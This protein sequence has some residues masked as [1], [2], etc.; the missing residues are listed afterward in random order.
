MLALTPQCKIFLAIEP[1]DFRKGI[2]ALAAVCRQKLKEEPFSGTLFV[3]SNRSRT[4]I[5]ILTYDG[6]GFWLLMQRLSRGKF[7]WW[8]KADG[9][10]HPL[11][12]SQLQILLWNGNPTNA[13]IQ[14]DWRKIA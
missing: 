14:E 4:A 10:I 7:Y 11:S 5:R 2:D 13:Q 9:S 12:A 8:P 6:Q 1:C 3:F